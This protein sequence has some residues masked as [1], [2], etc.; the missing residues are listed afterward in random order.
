VAQL[1]WSGDAPATRVES[2]AL[3]TLASDLLVRDFLRWHT[4]LDDAALKEL[5]GDDVQLGRSVQDSVMVYGFKG[6]SRLWRMPAGAVRRESV[7]DVSGGSVAKLA[8]RAAK[9]DW[10]A[11]RTQGGVGRFRIDASLPGVTSETSASSAKA[12]PADDPEETIAAKTQEWF[13][14][15]EPLARPDGG[16]HRKPP[17]LSQWLAIVGEM[18]ANGPNALTSRLNPTAASGQS[19]KHNG[20]KAILDELNNVQL[21]QRRLYARLFLRWLRA[22]GR[23]CQGLGAR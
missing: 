4:V 21:P 1:A 17:S 11:E 15:Y 8:E 18:E 19:W 14:A 5:L 7:F 9:D 23:S 6:A 10:L 13:N 22:E 20:A 12:P 3:L 2:K 16:N